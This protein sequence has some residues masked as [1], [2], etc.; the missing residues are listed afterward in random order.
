M[1]VKSKLCPYV[2][3]TLVAC[4]Y[5]LS[6]P[7]PGEKHVR[8]RKRPFSPSLSTVDSSDDELTVKKDMPVV[9]IPIFVFCDPSTYVTLKI[10]Q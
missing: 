6:S 8:K 7:K 1:K 5:H 10:R 4:G 9:C 2:K 3:V